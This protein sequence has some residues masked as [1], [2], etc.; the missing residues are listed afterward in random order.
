VLGE[1]SGQHHSPSA[2]P[3]GKDPLVPFQQEA[4]QAPEQVWMSWRR[5]KSLAPTG[6]QTE[7]YH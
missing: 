6:I 1:V 5:V 4:R 2:L 3:L 7:D